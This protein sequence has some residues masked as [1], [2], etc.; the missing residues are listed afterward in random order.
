MDCRVSAFQHFC[1]PRGLAANSESSNSSGIMVFSI[2]AMR[3]ISDSSKRRNLLN[4]QIDPTTL[5]SPA[6]YINELVLLFAMVPAIDQHDIIAEFGHHRL[7]FFSISWF[8]VT[9]DTYCIMFKLM[10]VCNNCGMSSLGR[11]EPFDIYNFL[12]MNLSLEQNILV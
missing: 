12:V 10:F 3:R 2:R 4:C 6:T 5:L 8:F 7:F 11:L 9:H 1:C